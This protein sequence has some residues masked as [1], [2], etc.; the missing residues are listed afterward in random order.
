M[1]A[2]EAP[3]PA[4]PLAAWRLA[5]NLLAYQAGWAAAVLGAAHGRPWLGAG[6]ALL[7]VVM[8]LALTRP[9]L[10]E[11]RL[12][13][14]VTVLGCAVDTAQAALGVFRFGEPGWPAWLCP[15]WLAAVW[16]LF[17]TTLRV[18]LRWLRSRPVHAALL[19]AIGGPLAYGGGVRLGAVT[20]DWP[21]GW[22]LLELALLWAA[23]VP[24][25]VSLAGRLDGTRRGHT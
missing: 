8:H 9:V 14:A 20:A 1:R 16:A 22:M 19:G 7:L 6:A 17:A 18:G 21:A 24:A 5:V 11:L 15:P 4:A 12:V 3:A 23:L 25:L 13:V 2:L 10:P